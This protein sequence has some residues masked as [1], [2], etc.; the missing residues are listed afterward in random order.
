MTVKVTSIKSARTVCNETGNMRGPSRLHRSDMILE[1]SHRFQVSSKLELQMFR[2]I[3]TIYE[4]IYTNELLQDTHIP[5]YSRRFAD[6]TM[7]KIGN[8]TLLQDFLAIPK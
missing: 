6:V 3:Y 5:V 2:F 1:G 7:H 8:I 4:L